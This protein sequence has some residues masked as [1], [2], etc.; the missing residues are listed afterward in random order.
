MNEIMVSIQN[1]PASKGLRYGLVEHFNSR[2]EASNQMSAYIHKLDKG[3]L[4]A[5]NIVRHLNY[6]LLNILSRPN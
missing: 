4:D 5:I 1:T 2:S 6:M 3:I